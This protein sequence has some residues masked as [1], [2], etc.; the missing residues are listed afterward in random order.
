MVE[1]GG[2]ERRRGTD[3]MELIDSYSRSYRLNRPYRI[4]ALQLCYSF[5]RCPESSSVIGD[6]RNGRGRL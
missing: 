1:A 3:T 2:V 4:T 6:R 5:R